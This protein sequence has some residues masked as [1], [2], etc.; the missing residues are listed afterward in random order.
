MSLAQ[1]RY[2]GGPPPVCYKQPPIGPPP[3]PGFP[4]PQLSIIVHWQD[5][6]PYNPW[7]SIELFKLTPTIFP[8]LWAGNSDPPPQY[9]RAVLE[10][11]YGTDDWHAYLE[12]TKPDRVTLAAAIPIGYVNP[13]RPFDTNLVQYPG[14]PFDYKVEI[15]ITS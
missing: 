14:P 5:F 1:R 9:F 12:S 10:Q 7:D 6:P 3:P 13:S 8:R 4:F 15:R 2:I 11:N